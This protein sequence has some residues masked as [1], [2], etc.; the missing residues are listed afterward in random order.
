MYLQDVEMQD[1]TLSEALFQD[2]VFAETFDAM[3]A[4]A[5][6]NSGEYWAAAS[7]LGE[8]RVWADSGQTLR[9][10]WH[11]HADIIWALTFRPDGRALVS[12]CWDGTVRVWDILS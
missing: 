3:T 6:S 2:G 10:A 8:I 7:R 9:L 5:I 4:V 12:G 11:A 1:S